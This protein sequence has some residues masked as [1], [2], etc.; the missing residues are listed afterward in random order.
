[1]QARTPSPAGKNLSVGTET[2]YTCVSPELSFFQFSGPGKPLTSSGAS[3]GQRRNSA[4]EVL[5]S[6]D[7]GWHSPATHLVPFGHSGTTPYAHWMFSVADPAAAAEPVDVAATRMAA[8]KALSFM[9]DCRVGRQRSTVL[10]LFPLSRL[11]I[12]FWQA[13]LSPR[14]VVLH[15]SLLLSCLCLSDLGLELRA[16]ENGEKLPASRAR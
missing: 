14:T 5:P 11:S 12:K 13:S 3:P 6:N 7:T 15:G 8:A 16:A 10:S 4:P 9:F 1:M 2:L